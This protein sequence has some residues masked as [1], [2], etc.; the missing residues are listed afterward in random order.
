MV[1]R[2]GAA[3]GGFIGAVEGLIRMKPVGESLSGVVFEWEVACSHM[4]SRPRGQRQIQSRCSQMI[5][6]IALDHIENTYE[7]TNA[8]G[9][10]R[11]LDSW[12][13]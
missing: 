3:P 11:V 8:G 7:G 10:I 6:W 5:K 2:V 13:A 12:Q 9:P 4:V 1:V